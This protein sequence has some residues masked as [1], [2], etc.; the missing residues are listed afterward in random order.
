ML[1]ISKASFIFKYNRVNYTN[2][3]EKSDKEK[4]S[5]VMEKNR[6]SQMRQ[7]EYFTSVF[8]SIIYPPRMIYLGNSLKQSFIQ[9]K[10][11]ANFLLQKSN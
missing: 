8:F 6:K 2:F 7:E 3:K 9:F 4:H 10:P 11:F 5:V 1:S